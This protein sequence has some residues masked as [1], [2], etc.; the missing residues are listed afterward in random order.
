MAAI[1]GTVMERFINAANF[2][3]FARTQDIKIARNKKLRAD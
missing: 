3:L 2:I 1:K